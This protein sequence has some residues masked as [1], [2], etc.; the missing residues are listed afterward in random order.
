MQDHISL[1]IHQ[2]ANNLV[3]DKEGIFAREVAFLARIGLNIEAIKKVRAAANLGLKEAKDLYE[4]FRDETNKWSISSSASEFQRLFEKIN[5]TSKE[6]AFE[7]MI[8]DNASL[9]NRLAQVMEERDGLR[10][11]VNELQAWVN[12]AK[13]Q[14]AEDEHASCSSYI[15]GTSYLKQD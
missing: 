14:K 4:E 9:R 13:E 6:R 12:E 1:A 3:M 15:D 11:R 2:A 5:A 7:R 8:N 10:D